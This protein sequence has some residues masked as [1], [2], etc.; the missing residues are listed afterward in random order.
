MEWNAEFFRQAGLRTRHI[1]PFFRVRRETASGWL[2]GR[3]APAAA[4]SE[5]A[6]LLQRAVE[7]ALDDGRLPIHRAKDVSQHEHD[8]R[9]LQVL[10]IYV[11][12]QEEAG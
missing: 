9:V 2:N 1:T 5:Q 3:H 8:L 6:M 11:R 4:Y 10:D 7:A 12:R